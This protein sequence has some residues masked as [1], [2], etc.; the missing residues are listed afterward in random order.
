V[1][2]SAV[3]LIALAVL[4]AV[5]PPLTECAREGKTMALANGQSAPMRCH[6]TALASLAMA[7]PL[8][9]AGVMQWFSKRKENKR[10][11]S[12]LGM[13]MGAVVIAL[14]TV[15]IGVCAHPDATCNLV[16]R[17]ALIFMGTLV[18]GI[19]LIDLVMSERRP[20]QLA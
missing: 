2:I 19:N 20:E 4:I 3:L 8:F 15:L 6:W 9:V 12:I 17:P 1:K 13:A 10:S 7:L 11:L 16:M 14:P 5:V 18:I